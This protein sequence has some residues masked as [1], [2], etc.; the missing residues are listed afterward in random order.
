[1][2]NRTHRR[3]Q[4]KAARGFSPV[5]ALCCLALGA[6][7]ADNSA[8]DSPQP[9]DSPGAS[10]LETAT[11]WPLYRGTRGLGG[12]AAGNLPAQPELLWTFAAE[13]A[14]TS[15][16]VVAKGR[17]YFGSDDNNLYCVDADNGVLQWSFPTEDIIEAPPSVVDGTVYVGS[18][19]YFFYAID[20]ITGQLR[21]KFE[22]GDKIMGAANYLTT[23]KGVIIFF[24]SYD[25][26]LY[27]LDAATGDKLWQYTTDNYINGTPAVDGDLTCFG[28]CDA[29]LHVVSVSSGQGVAAITLEQDCH[30]AG[31]AA[32]ENGR[33]YFGHYGNQF[34]CLDLAAQKILWHYDSPRSAFFSSPALT[35]D[36]V[37]FG[38]RDK[39][40]HCVEKATGKPLWTF[41][42]GRKVDSSPVVCGDDVVFGSGDGRLYILELQSGQERWSYDIGK[43]LVSSPAVVAGK[44]YIGSNDSKLYAFGPGP[45]SHANPAT[46]PGNR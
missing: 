19:D 5:A 25:A 28:G 4:N 14:I 21:W 44:I 11:E 10:P 46:D 9:N 41:R 2:T 20:A 27:G 39:Q 42:T 24:G 15:S 12:V 13:G 32:T 18:N 31:S 30:I 8:P 35:Q 16:P 6:C 40:L 23:D 7:G 1:M 34:V 45:A 38:G 26:S 29:V 3:R 36:R 43:A 22:T 33:A 37:V 17:V